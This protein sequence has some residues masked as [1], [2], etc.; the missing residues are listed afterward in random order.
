MSRKTTKYVLVTGGVVS[1][2]GKG[3]A[4]EKRY[5][6][7]VVHLRRATELEPHYAEAWWNLGA[8]SS[9]AFV[10]FVIILIVTR[11]LLALHRRAFGEVTA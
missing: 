6:E 10:L 8:A 5:D 9:V 11:G 2:I 7:A 4:S 3:L 1:S